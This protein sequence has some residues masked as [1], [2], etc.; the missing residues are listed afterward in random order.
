MHPGQTTMCSTQFRL[1]HHSRPDRIPRWQ[2]LLRHADDRRSAPS[3]VIECVQRH[4]WD[5]RYGSIVI[6]VVGDEVFVNGDRVELHV[7]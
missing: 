1:H 7:P 2:V 5:S 6:E 3:L 4:V